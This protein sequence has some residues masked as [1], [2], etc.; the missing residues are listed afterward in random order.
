MKA[1]ITMIALVSSL[2]VMSSEIASGPSRVLA[3]KKDLIVVQI[4]GKAAQLLFSKLENTKEE[5]VQQGSLTKSIRVG[6]DITCEMQ[7]AFVVNYS[8]IMKFDDS[9]AIIK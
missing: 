3:D 4:Q 8:C 9:G 6:R 7:A 5:S 1:L 2:T